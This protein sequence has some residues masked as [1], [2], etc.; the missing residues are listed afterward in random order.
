[1]N[2][3]VKNPKIVKGDNQSFDN[4]TIRTLNQV[5]ED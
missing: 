3:N 4:A 1:M 5:N 2:R